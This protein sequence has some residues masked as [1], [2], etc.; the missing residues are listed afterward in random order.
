M[1]GGGEIMLN[2]RGGPGRVIFHALLAGAALLTLCSIN[3]CD[4]GEPSQTLSGSTL[5]PFASIAVLGDGIAM[6]GD[7]EETISIY[8]WDGKFIRT[9]KAP[10]GDEWSVLHDT[11][12]YQ[13]MESRKIDSVT[14][15]TTVGVYAKSYGH[16][17]Y[18]LQVDVKPLTPILSFGPA[19]MAANDRLYVFCVK[20]SDSGFLGT[21]R[22]VL[23]E[24][25]GLT[26]TRRWENVVLVNNESA[27]PTFYQDGSFFAIRGQRDEDVVEYPVELISPTSESFKHGTV[28]YFSTEREICIRRSGHLGGIM[29][30]NTDGDSRTY[31]FEGHNTEGQRTFSASRS[32]GINWY[33]QYRDELAVVVCSRD[34]GTSASVEIDL[35]SELGEGH[36]IRGIRAV[37]EYAYLWGRTADRGPY[38]VRLRDSG[39]QLTAE[40]KSMGGD[41]GEASMVLGHGFVARGDRAF[42]VVYDV[43]ELEKENLV[44][45]LVRVF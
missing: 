33:V 13:Y 24:F 39:G 6:M 5:E 7:D 21:G 35:A 32:D 17:N 12:S 36:A 26:E 8:D 45:S 42:M 41:V 44:Y 31:D 23:V 9:E 40:T 15:E 38:V 1:N 16:P 29:L 25:H 34:D 20:D 30:V 10:V 18:W 43:A 2:W 3:G 37:G 19:T 11:A 28:V 4:F 22:N 27:Y 14:H